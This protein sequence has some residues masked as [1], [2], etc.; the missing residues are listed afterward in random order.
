MDNIVKVGLS[1]AVG[2]L[3]ARYILLGKYKN[4]YVKVE[5]ETIDKIQNKLHDFLKGM[6]PDA[7][8]QEVAEA[9]LSVTN[10]TDTT[11]TGETT[12]VVTETPQSLN[13]GGGRNNSN[14]YAK[15]M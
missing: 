2:F 8:D 9:V 7:T 13:F 3:V 12:T 6:F 10:T 11:S 5:A 4:E 15:F 14:D 1:F